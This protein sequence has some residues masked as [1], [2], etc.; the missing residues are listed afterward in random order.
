MAN[1]LRSARNQRNAS[2]KGHFYRLPDQNNCMNRI[3]NYTCRDLR[4]SRGK[5]LQEFSSLLGSRRVAPHAHGE[6]AALA[7]SSRT[8]LRNRYRR[9]GGARM[10]VTAVM[11]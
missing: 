9:I 3:G 1:T 10:V 11:N 4:R 8:S 7:A 5:S 6:A 2:G